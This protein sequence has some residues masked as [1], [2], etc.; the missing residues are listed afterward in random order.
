MLSWRL[1]VRNCRRGGQ[2]FNLLN[3]ACRSPE[4]GDPLPAHIGFGPV[5]RHP[6]PVRRRRS[7]A[8]ADPDVVVTFR[9]PCPI[10]RNPYV[11]IA[12]GFIRW[13]VF[14]YVGRRLGR[15]NKGGLCVQVNRL[16]KGLVNGA[17]GQNLGLLFRWCRRRLGRVL[18]IQLAGR[19]NHYYRK[20]NR[21][22]HIFTLS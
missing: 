10:T 16:G 13:R 3:V 12:H 18:A 6:I 9:V 8:A 19:K 7:P 22:F 4:T 11:L 20:C 17:A 5:T 21:S 15:G 2:I 14:R 1:H